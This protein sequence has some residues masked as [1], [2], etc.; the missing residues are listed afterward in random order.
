MPNRRDFL[1]AGAGLVAGGMA[2]GT[3]SAATM[4][5]TIL[6]GTTPPANGLGRVGDFYIDVRTHAIYGP[7]RAKGWGK[8]TELIGP[9]GAKGPRGSAGS[10]G[11][12]GPMGYSVLHGSGP[13]SPSLGEDN[14][15]YIDTAATQLYGPKEGGVWGSPVSIG[16]TQAEVVVANPNHPWDENG[17]F[18]AVGSSL[19][20]IEPGG[21]TLAHSLIGIGGGVTTADQPTTGNLGQITTG[22][23][24]VAIGTPAMPEATTSYGCIAI[25]PDCQSY[26]TSGYYNTAVGAQALEHTT[27]GYQN[28]AVGQ[29][30]LGNN[31]TGAGNVAVGHTAGR[32]VDGTNNGVFIGEHAAQSLSGAASTV[33]IGGQAAD[34]STASLSSVTLVG[35]SSMQ[36]SGLTSSASNNVGVGDSVLNALTTGNQNTVIGS[37]SADALT[38]GD[39]N[40]LAGY[41]AGN[42]VTVGNG[43]TCLGAISGLALV[44]GSRS[45]CVGQGAGHTGSS[46]NS[47]MTLLGANTVGSGAGAV[48]IGIDSAGT[49]ASAASNVFA[50]GSPL[51][52]VKISNNATGSGSAALGSNCPA[53]TPA[54]P[55]VWFKMMSS[56]GST[57]YVPAW[58]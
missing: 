56:D 24:N 30:A 53:T 50:L 11:Q 26:L 1:A 45:T 14:D 4:T 6:H 2:Q 23:D 34:T 5:T 46:D 55:Y 29:G 9:K 44:T 36:G 48:A 54:A 27:T 17:Y 52:Q 35:A 47:C 33:I 13:P 20:N 31:M 8:P 10:P 15:F 57:V 3:A 22:Y 41:A 21:G 40:L 7:K 43:N 51:H 28:V 18:F 49:S 58:Q 32:S 39:D 16:V 42:A 25:G 19:S 38:T 12:I 37:Q